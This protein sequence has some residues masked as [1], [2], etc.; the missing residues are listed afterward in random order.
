MSPILNRKSSTELKPR[1]KKS[2]TVR[3]A[4]LLRE[5]LHAAPWVFLP[6]LSTNSLANTGKYA[7]GTQTSADSLS[8]YLLLDSYARQ[9]VRLRD[10]SKSCSLPLRCLENSRVADKR[11]VSLSPLQIQT[12]LT[13][14]P[15]CH[16]AQAR[17]QH[18]ADPGA[19][20]CT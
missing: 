1:A 14:S 18:I 20:L 16:R 7:V 4:N 11:K 6:P 3:V 10:E 12:T 9:S 13:R 8:Q 5:Q 2:N 19:T 15:N 17:T